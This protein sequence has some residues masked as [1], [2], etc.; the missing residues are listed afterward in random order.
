MLQRNPP[1]AVPVASLTT[2][3]TNLPSLRMLQGQ[4]TRNIHSPAPIC[5]AMRAESQFPRATTTSHVQIG[6]DLVN[7]KLAIA[8]SSA[9]RSGGRCRSEDRRVG[10]ECR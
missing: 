8:G 9:E 1:G 4:W 6:C 7:L 3:M 2:R 5:E 10:K